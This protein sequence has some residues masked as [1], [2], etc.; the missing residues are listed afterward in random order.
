MPSSNSPERS[1]P[2]EAAATV[3][4][5]RG[6]NTHSTEEPADV[7]SAELAL[8]DNSD[9][10]VSLPDEEL[11]DETDQALIQ[12][13]RTDICVSLGLL[14]SRAKPHFDTA[15]EEKPDFFW[16][17]TDEDDATTLYCGYKGFHA[18]SA[19]LAAP[20]S[21]IRVSDIAQAN[22]SDPAAVS[23][24]ARRLS[25]QNPV[26]IRP[27]INTEGEVEFFATTDQV[28]RITATLQKRQAREKTENLQADFHR[29]TEE[30][31]AGSSLEAQD[32]M[33]LIGL[34][35][36]E[37]A[38]DL[39]LQFKPEYRAIPIGYIKS[40]LADYMGDF[41]VVKGEINFE[42]LDMSVEF[43][44]DMGLKKALTEVI[45]RDCLSSYH[46]K[47]RGDPTRD[48]LEIVSRYLGKLRD[49]VSMLKST[50]L[51]EVLDS[52]DQY[53]LE[54]FLEFTTPS[55][56]IEGLR[57]D[58]PFPDLNQR[59][60]IKEISD[61]KRLLIADEPG[62][63]K[64]ASAILAKEHVGADLAVVIAPSQVIDKDIWQDYLSDKIGPDG[65]PIGYF[66]PGQAPRVLV[67]RGP[68]S[69]VGVKKEDFDYILISQESLKPEYVD[70]LKEIGFD[71]LIVDEAHKLKNINDGLRSQQLLQLSDYLDEKEDTYTLMLTATPAPNKVSDIAM[72]LRVM[73]PKQFAQY[74]SKELA[75]MMINGDLL[76]LRSLLVPIMQMKLLEDSVDMPPHEEIIDYVTISPRERELYELEIDNDEI[77]FAAKIHAL[78]QTLLNP[79]A[80][81]A[82]PAIVPSKAARLNEVINEGLTNGKRKFLVFVNDYKEHVLSGKSTLA[83]F[84]NLPPDVQ[85]R[86]IHGD[87]S[88]KDRP[89]IQ[90]EFQ[91][92]QGRI[93]LLVSGQTADVGVDFSAT[94]DMTF[95]NEGWTLPEKRQEIGRGLRPNR[96]GPLTI[97]TLIARGTIEEGIHEYIKSKDRMIHKLLHGIPL[98]DLEKQFLHSDEDENL[99]A[100]FEVNPTIASHYMSAMQRINKMFGNVK[101]GGEAKTR[102]TLKKHGAEYASTYQELTNRSYQANMA[103]LTGTI[104]TNMSRDGKLH[105]N[106]VILDLG[107]GPEMLRRHISKRLSQQVVSLD[108]NSHHFAEKSAT[109]RVV[110]S[111]VS[112]AA[113]SQSVDVVSM[114]LVLDS[115]K[116]MTSKRG[117][118]P[119]ALER[120]AIMTEINRVLKPGGT[121]VI[122]QIYSLDFEDVPA[123]ERLMKKIG[124]EVVRP[125]SGLVY[126]KSELRGRVVTLKKVSEIPTITETSGE[127]QTTRPQTPKEIIDRLEPGIAGGLRFSSRNARV[128]DPK[129]V[130]REYRIKHGKNSETILPIFNELDREIMQEEEVI[131]SSMQQLKSKYG[132][133]GTIPPD[134]IAASGMAR[135]ALNKQHI[136]FRSLSM[137]GGAIQLRQKSNKNK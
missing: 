126:S 5:F 55:N 57:P 46:Q 78:R 17:G 64:S 34:F 39:L 27:H 123:F 48:E 86:F 70:A 100:A 21:M 63:G 19:Q 44:S 80:V 24:V 90:S 65:Q 92:S 66:K 75:H 47:R 28:A 43:L 67:F 16:L 121:A 107:S 14:P 42:H 108:I 94:D 73:Y 68:A 69:L 133:I 134:V 119:E 98:S 15:V 111:V 88:I 22:E 33:K 9:V 91:N 7:S 83:D 76:E 81:E 87:V 58:R 105:D 104:I 124:F 4:P 129:V 125:T 60:N 53:F 59:I 31:Q 102:R 112:I 130:D 117:S 25:R 135:I 40:R 122:T 77:E 93:V 35:G 52:V 10:E 101:Q 41:L 114:G 136:L 50:E 26:E 115:T 8:V 113:G 37:S 23:A 74:D 45:K 20:E 13:T 18:V 1:G 2:P 56:V 62:L 38:C 61:K 12:F 30:V 49:Q 116:Y 137:G 3:L 106:P 97:R 103:R 131:L 82:T 127:V 11:T 120:L 118:D 32:Y 99:D 96:T 54:V 72:I 109:P 110:G 95:Y 89:A 132:A 36:A 6:R 128:K 85:I 51:N 71:M 29:F 84:L 79:A